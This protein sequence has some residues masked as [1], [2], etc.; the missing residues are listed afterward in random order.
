MEKTYKAILNQI[1]EAVNPNRKLGTVKTNK[2]ITLS[3]RDVS[4]VNNQN[5]INLSW[6]KRYY[7]YD[8]GKY[9][10]LD[11]YSFNAYSSQ[12]LRTTTFANYGN[13]N[14]FVEDA[15]SNIQ[16]STSVYVEKNILIEFNPKVQDG[17]LAI[18]NGDTEI[19][20]TGNEEPFLS[21]KIYI[22]LQAGWNDLYVYIYVQKAKHTITI[23]GDIAKKVVSWKNIDFTPPSIPTWDPIR[24]V[25]VEY[26]NAEVSKDLKIV[27]R[28]VNSAFNNSA[29][30]LKGWGMYEI[31]T[32]YVADENDA[33]L[34]IDSLGA[35]YPYDNDY[36][37]SFNVIGDRR[38]YFPVSS[39]LPRIAG[40]YGDYIV[41][42]TVYHRD[43]N[44]TEVQIKPQIKGDGNLGSV[45][46]G[47]TAFVA[48]EKY[49]HIQ[50][51][52]R[53][54][55]S[56]YIVSGTIRAD[57]NY[58]QTKRIVLDSFDDSINR[59]RSA[60]STYKDAWITIPVVNYP[61]P[62]VDVV[63]GTQGGL[64]SVLAVL[65]NPK[66]WDTPRVDVRGFKIWNQDNPLRKHM[67]L[68]VP[69]VISG[70]GYTDILALVDKYYDSSADTR[71]P[72]KDKTEYTFY[73]SCYDWYGNSILTGLPSFTDKTVVS[74][75]TDP[76]DAHVELD[77]ETN[78]LKIFAKLIDTP[79]V[80]RD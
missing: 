77:S 78:C 3:Y 66:E 75:R 29:S 72:L 21:N 56:G 53:D 31:V 70:S 27:L 58:G 80:S 63:V 6:N 28:W 79:I 61:K 23:E 65:N 12:I 42:G 60:K 68:D 57:M 7:S 4:D 39:I 13:I 48:I 14:D 38:T 49:F 45:I 35:V 74:V 24:P 71:L 11:K 25:S 54:A 8:R 30:D 22:S 15:Y 43:T 59:N 62:P 16:Y 2:P 32:E 36:Y 50:D 10:P 40:V 47:T 33:Y 1:D 18:F 69:V 34:Y 19:L 5:V 41:S 67:L 46:P 37:T 73:V 76:G 44:L 9:F 52:S 17:S 20:T 26:I 51:V 55:T 64:K